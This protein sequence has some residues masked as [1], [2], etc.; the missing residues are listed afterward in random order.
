MTNNKR[1][2]DEAVHQ[3]LAAVITVKMMEIMD[4]IAGDNPVYHLTR[5]L[6]IS[7]LL[8][9]AYHSVKVEREAVQ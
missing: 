1:T 3:I 8:Y 5:P 2:I 4:K 6:L 9:S 7:S